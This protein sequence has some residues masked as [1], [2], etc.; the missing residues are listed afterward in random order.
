MIIDFR[1]DPDTARRYDVICAR[2]GERLD[3][4]IWYADDVNGVVR[5]YRKDEFGLFMED[6]QGTGALWE[7]RYKA[8]KIVRKSPAEIA[9]IEEFERQFAEDAVL[10]ATLVDTVQ[11]LAAEDR[12]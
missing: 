3:W 5:C 10:L 7:E 9:E 12:P 4:P 8:I 11:G 1:D 6:A 2:T